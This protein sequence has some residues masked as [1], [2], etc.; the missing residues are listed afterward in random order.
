MLPDIPD[1]IPCRQEHNYLTH[2]L[3][4]QLSSWQSHVLLAVATHEKAIQAQ[5]PSPEILLWLSFL[6]LSGDVRY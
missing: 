1:F 2:G 5:A 6:R 3:V 4:G